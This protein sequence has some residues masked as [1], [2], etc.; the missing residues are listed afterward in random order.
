MHAYKLSKLIE[1]FLFGKSF[2][3]SKFTFIWMKS[4][5]KA[6]KTSFGQLCGS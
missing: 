2:F 6:S 4:N 5:I 3:P 1:E